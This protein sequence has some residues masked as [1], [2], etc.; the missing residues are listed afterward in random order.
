MRRRHS[1]NPIGTAL[2]PATRLGPTEPLPFLGRRRELTDLESVL[3]RRGVVCLVGALGVG[4][5]ELGR[6]LIARAQAAGRRTAFVSIQRGDDVDAI[7][8]RAER[9]LGVPPDGLADAVA[10]APTLV[11][12][13]DVHRLGTDVKRLARLPG[14]V[15][16]L[17][18]EKCAVSGL[19]SSTLDG[20]AVDDARA[21]WMRLE[22]THG[23][24]P[25]GVCD[26]ALVTTQGRPLGLRREFARARLEVEDPWDLDQLTEDESR[27]L[28]AA[29]VLGPAPA[30]ALG[31]LAAR[32]VEPGL[33]S[34]V[35]RQLLAAR[36]GGRF[37]VH[38][39]IGAEVL[40]R[41][42]PVERRRL[43]ADAG[44]L[45]TGRAQTWQRVGGDAAP[46]DPCERALCAAGHFFEAER[47][48][49]AT[50]VLVENENLLLE[51]GAGGELRALLGR[52]AGLRRDPSLKIGRAHV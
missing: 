3:E 33:R 23:P 26:G 49:E 25:Q 7:L 6:A 5:T 27:L 9:F 36:E 16:L 8:A 47:Q 42:D 12:F 20:L 4:K 31:I 37:A 43:E 13:D 45:L 2:G 10:A 44:S 32:Q 50:A 28:A 40:S 24:T 39:A 18:E 48:D 17:S 22:E 30:A 1:A 51:R 38:D 46:T 52:M 21:L 14:W 15:L 35:E 11:V 41:L 19:A 29:A 34:L